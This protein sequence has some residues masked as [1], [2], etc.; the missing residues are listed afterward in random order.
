MCY[1]YLFFLKIKKESVRINEPRLRSYN[2]TGYD[3]N[4]DD[5]RH[6]HNINTQ[7]DDYGA[8]GPEVE[9]KDAEHGT[10]WKKVALISTTLLVILVIAG[11]AVGIFYALRNTSG[12]KKMIKSL[13]KN[14]VSIN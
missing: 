14:C 1:L 10:N 4:F 13:D 2:N 7:R 8:C 5:I 12:K 3:G 11:A 9:R 6:E